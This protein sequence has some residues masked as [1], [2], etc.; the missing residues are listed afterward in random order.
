MVAPYEIGD[1]VRSYVRVTGSGSDKTAKSLCCD[2]S[3]V[4]QVAAAAPVPRNHVQE[5]QATTEEEATA[6]VEEGTQIGL[7]NRETEQVSQITPGEQQRQESRPMEPE[8]RKRPYPAAS[9]DVEGESSNAALP[10][11]KC[12]RITAGEECESAEAAT[13][14]VTALVKIST[15]TKVPGE[16]LINFAMRL[17]DLILVVKDNVPALEKMAEQA[18][19][20]Q[21]LAESPKGVVTKFVERSRSCIYI[22]KKK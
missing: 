2:L 21:V 7:N 11:N 5:P 20:R 15:S 16:T 19:A 1:P 9:E 14:A 12:A 10:P 3:R 18:V 22:P 6:S 4:S 17:K 13:A 8:G